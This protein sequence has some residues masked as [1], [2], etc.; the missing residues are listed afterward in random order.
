MSLRRRRRALLLFAAAAML[1]VSVSHAA[2]A[3]NIKVEQKVDYLGSPNNIRISNGTVE[4][5]IAT[6]YGPRVMRYALAGSGPDDNV[7]A[8]IP[9]VTVKSELGD[10]YIRGGH[11]LWHAPEGMPRSCFRPS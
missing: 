6:D 8:T 3:Q 10:W 4:L 5:I 2:R 9:G 7:F 1:A 11:R